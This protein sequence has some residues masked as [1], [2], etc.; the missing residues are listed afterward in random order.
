M[1]MDQRGKLWIIEVN[2]A[3]PSYGLFNRL[4]DKAYYHKIKAL[5]KAYRK[6]RKTH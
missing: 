2:L 4:P 3:Y 5:A 1:G 6:R